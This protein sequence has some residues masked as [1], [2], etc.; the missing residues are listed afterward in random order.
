MPFDKSQVNHK[1]CKEIVIP[2]FFLFFWL[3]NILLSLLVVVVCRLL[4][5]VEVRPVV[6][7]MKVEYSCI[8]AEG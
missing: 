3:Q 5:M 2:G 7:K 4:L 8:Q 1:T 6:P